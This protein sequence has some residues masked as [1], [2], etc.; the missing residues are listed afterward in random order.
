M[1]SLHTGSDILIYIQT[2]CFS[3]T[4]KGTA[5]HPSFP[6]VTF[7]EKESVLRIT[8]D[9][10]VDVI[11]LCG[12]H[13]MVSELHNEHLHVYEYQLVPLFFEQQRY[14]IIIEPEE[15]HRAKFWH[16]NYNIRKKLL[17]QD[18]KVIFLL[19]R[20]ISGMILVFRICLLK[21]TDQNS[22]S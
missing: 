5:T 1:D 22:S 20:S 7:S 11:D 3:L 18:E 6:G 8:S 4:I 16:D 13:D 19:V 2:S 15:N 14:E 12:D 21:L 10:E 17:R 9:E